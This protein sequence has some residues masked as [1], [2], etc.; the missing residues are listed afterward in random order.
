M[1]S[2]LV[3]ECRGL[4]KNSE[5]TALANTAAIKTSLR[6]PAGFRDSPRAWTVVVAGMVGLALGLSPL[7]FYTI[8]MFAPELA[9]AYGWSFTE[10]MTSV[11]VQSLVVVGSGPLAGFALD[12]YG[13]RRVALVSMPLFG[14]AFMSLAFAGSSLWLYYAQWVV[15]SI[16]GAGTLTATWT[17]VVNG[18]FDRYR[19]LALG[20]VSSG[21]G[22]TAFLVKPLTAWLI[23]EFGWRVAVGVI[24]ALPLV[25]A[26]PVLFFLFR[27]P[28]RGGAPVSG[29][30]GSGADDDAMAALAAVVEPG[31]TLAEALRDRRLWIMAGA[32]LLLAFALTATTPNM[33]NILKSHQFS[34]PQIGAITAAFGLA[35]IAG[36]VGGGLL[37]DRLWA[38][39][40]ALVIFAM[41]A[42]GNALLAGASVTKT[43]ALFS[44]IGMGLGTGFEF[45]LLAYMIARYF[46]RRQYGS[47]YGV[48]YIVIAIG[49]GLGPAVYG[50][51]FDRMGTYAPALWGGVGCILAGSLLL[52]LMGPY[53][54]GR[55]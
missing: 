15:M 25:I 13:S 41:P 26:W 30:P 39:G 14:L 12:R 29:A 20:M 44:I 2:R 24:G 33:E 10:L 47:I 3:R 4:A 49:G 53:P 22:L 1:S 52:L 27:E 46:G 9:K 48:F 6:T 7:P 43:S 16:V 11:T 37:L 28:P 45:D 21:T 31:A 19:G 5:G 35:V 38:P 32:F 55:E 42:L 17:R 8:G 51:V 50:Y 40:C 34:L 18:W 36:R 23:G 54:E